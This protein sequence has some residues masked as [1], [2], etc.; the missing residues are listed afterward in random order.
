MSLTECPICK[1]ESFDLQEVISKELSD[2]WKL[3]KK[4]I[5][6]INY[7]QGYHCVNCKSNLRVM[8]LADCIVKFFHSRDS[9]QD[10]AQKFDKKILEIN[11]A[12]N[13][14]PFLSMM[15]DHTLLEYPDIDMQNILFEDDSFDVVVHS[16]TLEH[17]PNS[18][19]ALEEC[20]RILKSNGVMFFTIPIVHDRLTVKRHGMPLSYH[21]DY[22]KHDEDQIVFSEFGANFY[23]EIIES[24]FKSVS[25]HTLENVA[26]LAIVAVKT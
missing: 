23:V 17:V 25:M 13:L 12:G 5:E 3:T 14:S 2:D 15:K 1:N 4:E 20:Y 11:Q 26:S 7:Q 21:G 8:T 19:R 10:F 16:D 18:L 22:K 9:F 24:G 6:Y